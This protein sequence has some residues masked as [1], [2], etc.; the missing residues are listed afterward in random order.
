M[1]EQKRPPEPKDAD[2]PKPSKDE[3]PPQ[4]P[5]KTW[6]EILEEDRFEATDN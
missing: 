2:K 6:Q 1:A 3:K 5:T 4:V